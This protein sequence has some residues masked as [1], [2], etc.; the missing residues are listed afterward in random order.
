MEV[1]DRGIEQAADR[2]SKELKGGWY[3]HFWDD[4]AVYICFPGKVFIIP[5]E[6]KWSSKEFQE[7]K[8]YAT[9]IGIE[10]RYLGFRV[11]D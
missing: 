9:K 10:E 11:E 8:E 2:F 5:R 6:E 7:V 3:C 1:E 4:K